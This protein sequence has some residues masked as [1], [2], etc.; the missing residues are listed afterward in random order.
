MVRSGW[1]KAPVRS[2]DQPSSVE[3][4]K[5]VLVDADQGTDADLLGRLEPGDGR[6]EVAGGE[7]APRQFG[8]PGG[9]LDEVDAV[10]LGLG[11]PVPP[12]LAGHGRRPQPATR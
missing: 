2:G 9:T 3:P 8:L 11:R 12:G 5:T 1:S 10:A 7:P 6:G 4:K